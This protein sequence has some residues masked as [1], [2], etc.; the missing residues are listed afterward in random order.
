MPPVGR[1]APKITEPAPLDGAFDGPAPGRPLMEGK[2]LTP[3]RKIAGADLFVFFAILAQPF[4]ASSLCLYGFDPVKSWALVLASAFVASVALWKGAVSTIPAGGKPFGSAAAIPAALAFAALTF[5]VV[6]ASDGRWTAILGGNARR[7]G[8]ITEVA[9][10]GVFVAAVLAVARGSLVPKDLAWGVAV[11]AAGGSAAGVCQSHWVARLD[12]TPWSGEVLNRVAG[13]MGS[14]SQL[15]SYLAI[16]IPVTLSSTFSALARR[17]RAVAIG[18]LL[19]VALQVVALMLTRGRAGTLGAAAGVF[20]VVAHTPFQSKLGRSFRG[21]TVAVLAAAALIVVILNVP[22]NPLVRFTQGRSPIA[23]WLERLA[24]VSNFTSGSGR[25]RALIS[26]SMIDALDERPRAWLVGFGPDLAWSALAPHDREERRRIE[27]LHTSVDRPHQFGA[28]KLLAGG[29]PYWSAWFAILTI[30]AGLGATACGNGR[31]SGKRWTRLESIPLTAGTLAGVAWFLGSAHP[32]LAFAVASLTSA[33]V[34]LVLAAVRGFGAGRTARLHGQTA[35]DVTYLS[36]FAGGL[37]GHLIAGSFSVSMG[38]ER[39]LAYALSGCVWGCAE[40]VHGGKPTIAVTSSVPS[41]VCG[42][43]VGAACGAIVPYFAYLLLSGTSIR[44]PIVVAVFPAVVGIVGALTLGADRRRFFAWA[45]LISTPAVLLLTLVAILE[46]RQAFQT[47]RE[48]TWASYLTP[49][50]LVWTALA[51]AFSGSDGDRSSVE[52]VSAATEQRS[53]RRESMAGA[54]SALALAAGLLATWVGTAELRSDCLYLAAIHANEAARQL[55]ERA[56]FK[57]SDFGRQ[58]ALREQAEAVNAKALELLD[59][60]RAIGSPL[61]PLGCPAP[62]DRVI[63][64]ER[65]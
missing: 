48:P 58:A 13:V 29:L 39:T 61:A 14:P 47:G 28:E 18:M 63:P 31:E 53:T 64:S 25:V 27:G 45:A 6:F 33:G 46:G 1:R 37:V 4:A 40:R 12:P 11:A 52:R 55:D 2:A 34:L 23:H 59:R 22:G 65:P 54:L 5:G 26:D 7:Q 42:R 36:G 49:A 19:S 24:Q 8:W 56:A 50:V 43:W 62:L 16:T 21:A 10:L 41:S 15:S 30:A 20:L 44:P 60:A 32:G 17:D 51:F 57:E 38:P 9:E 3:M 35:W